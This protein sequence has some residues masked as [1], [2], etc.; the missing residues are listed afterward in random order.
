MSPR[1]LASGLEAASIFFS[2]EVRRLFYQ[3]DLLY[4]KKNKQKTQKTEQEKKRKMRQVRVTE[5]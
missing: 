3:T 4:K 2:F 5:L 1:S